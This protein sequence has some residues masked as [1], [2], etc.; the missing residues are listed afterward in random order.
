MSKQTFNQCVVPLITYGSETWNM[1]K[2][3]ERKLACA[4]RGMERFKLGNGQ[5]DRKRTKWIRKETKVEYIIKN[6]KIHID[7]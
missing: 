3:F 4:Q 5:R 2:L 1:Q 7:R 6:I